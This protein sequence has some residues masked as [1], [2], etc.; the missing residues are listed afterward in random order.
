MLKKSYGSLG[1]YLR[2]VLRNITG[3]AWHPML[4]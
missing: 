3:L 4:I 1:C 2:L